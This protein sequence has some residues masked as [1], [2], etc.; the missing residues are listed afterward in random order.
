[1]QLFGCIVN[2]LTP[3]KR[4]E[5]NTDLSHVLEKFLPE[6]FGT[7]GRQFGQPALLNARALTIMNLS[8]RRR[9]I[10]FHSRAS[11][12]KKAWAKRREASAS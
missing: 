5:S 9:S 10:P 4:S 2:V 8:N 7:T 12:S 3:I 6:S 11:V 1:M